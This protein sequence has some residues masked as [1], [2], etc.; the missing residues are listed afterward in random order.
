MANDNVTLRAHAKIN[1][2][3]NVCSRRADGYHILD[4]L[5]QRIDVH[6][7]LQFSPADSLTMTVEGGPEGLSLEDNLVMRAA[8]ALKE[9]TGHPGGARIR[10]QK[11]IPAMAGLGGGSADA[12]ATL[13]GLNRLWG[14][15]LGVYQLQEIGLRMGADVPLCLCDGLMRVKGIGEDIVQLP[16]ARVYH[17]LILQSGNGLSTRE[18]FRRHDLQPDV[19]PAQLDL[20]TDAL[21]QQDFEGIRT[22]C[23]NQLQPTAASMLT[24][25]GDA[26]A[27]LQDSGA[28]FAQMT[29][30]GSAVFGVFETKE[31]AAAAQA[32]LKDAW[33]VC[34]QTTTLTD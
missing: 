12:A 14:L 3:L 18:V 4:M 26:A 11:H 17:L 21:R 22:N 13:T 20:A 5:V 16:H 30:S 15:G 10:L 19:E 23:K 33:P 2:A 25:I 24:D 32:R 6:D 27:A 28:A 9:A 1:W 8:R 7:L 31:A 29:G 34:I